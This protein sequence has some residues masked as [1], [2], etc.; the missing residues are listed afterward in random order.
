MY[1]H[2]MERMQMSKS[3]ASTKL[4]LFRFNPLGDNGFV[5]EIW[6]PVRPWASFP[7]PSEPEGSGEDDRFPRFCHIRF[8]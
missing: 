5:V 4:A 6:Q 7:G 3:V 1:D 8:C 2:T